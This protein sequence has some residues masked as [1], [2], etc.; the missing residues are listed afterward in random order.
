MDYIETSAKTGKNVSEAFAKITETIYKKVEAGIID[1]TQDTSGVRLGTE[2]KM[3]Q[4]T[5]SKISLGKQK[6]PQGGS[7]C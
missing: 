1:V 6:T 5:D 4:V 7:C 3:G 2:V